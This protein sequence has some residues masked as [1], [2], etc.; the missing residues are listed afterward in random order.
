VCVYVYIFHGGVSARGA[1]APPTVW[2]VCRGGLAGRG[3]VFG[4]GQRD[5]ARVPRTGRARGV[6]RV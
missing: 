2:R 5:G 1:A 4:G 6:R 3:G